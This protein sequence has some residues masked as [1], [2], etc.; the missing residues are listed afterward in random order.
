M[1]SQ[2][3]P[4]ITQYNT[5]IH[6]FLCL[7]ENDLL[8]SQLKLWFLIIVAHRK[9]LKNLVPQKIPSTLLSLWFSDEHRFSSKF[10]NLTHKIC[11]QKTVLIKYA[12]NHPAVLWK[13]FHRCFILS[14]VKLCRR[15]SSKVSVFSSQFILPCGAHI[16]LQVT[17]IKQIK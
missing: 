11:F 14:S 3:W 4:P 10:W 5:A 1:G 8:L 7:F 16:V 17:Y 6:E 12:K 13:S 15:N 2:L 9:H